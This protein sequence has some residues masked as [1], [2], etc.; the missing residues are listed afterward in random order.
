MSEEKDPLDDLLNFSRRP[1]KQ[2]NRAAEPVDKTDDKG[3]NPL[4]ILSLPRDQRE[5][6]NWLSRRS[7]CRIDEI[8]AGLGKERE[9]IEATLAALK[10]TDYVHEALI[11]GEVYYRV[12]FR[13]KVKRTTR[14]LPQHLWARVDLD[15]V[16]FLQQVPLFQGLPQDWLKKIA[17]KLE[18][19]R[20]QRNEVILWQGSLNENIFFIKNGIVGITRLSS[21]TQDVH[22]LAYRNQGDHFG[23]FSLFTEQGTTTATVTALSEVNVLTMTHGDF[24]AL[25]RD[26]HATAME[27][28][29]VLMQRLRETSDRAGNRPLTRNLCLVLGV[30]TGAGATTIASAIAAAATL[31]TEEPVVYTEHP[32]RHELPTLFGFELGAEK[33]RHRDGYDIFVSQDNPNLLPSVRMS[34]ILDQL[35]KDYSTLVVS[36]PGRVDETINNLLERANQ[37]VIVCPPD[38]WAEVERLKGFLD[39]T[40]YLKNKH[41][42]TVANFRRPEEEAQPVPDGADFFMPYLSDM[43]PISERDF[44]RLPSP[45]VKIATVLADRVQ[46]QNQLCIYLP[47]VVEIEEGQT[48][49]TGEQVEKTVAFLEALFDNATRTETKAEWQGEHGP[50]DGGIHAITSRMSQA[51]MSAHLQDVIRYVEAVKADLNQELL[52]LEVNHSL[53]LV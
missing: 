46:R 18:E 29:R 1:R 14:G 27:V 30:G 32:N 23:E 8:Q 15:N 37:I 20:Y 31:Q 34:L 53:V 11:D 9:D 21:R 2:R 28:M 25:L 24:T 3:L 51:D 26:Q 43:S 4:D 38:Q 16:A 5:M 22:L 33:Y 42:I 48:Q 17:D 44:D 49:P 39:K 40:I 13:G 36:V 19:R 45:L 7:D 12:V 35:L 52:A 50:A 6:V 41:L 47:S 10:K